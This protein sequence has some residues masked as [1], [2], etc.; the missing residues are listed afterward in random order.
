R[1]RARDLPLSLRGCSGTRGVPAARALL[2]PVVAPLRPL[3]AAPTAQGCGTSARARL[4]PPAPGGRPPSPVAGR[5]RARRV[6]LPPPPTVG[7][8]GARPVAAPYCAPHRP[9]APALRALRPD[10]RAQ[11]Q[12]PG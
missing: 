6:P 12:R 5:A 9:V 3:G 8:H 1:G 2:P 10:R 7:L 4:A 11:P